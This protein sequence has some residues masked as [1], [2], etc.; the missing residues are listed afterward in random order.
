[1]VNMNL[2]LGIENRCQ[3]SNFVLKK[4]AIVRAHEYVRT[5]KSVFV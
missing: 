4:E 3:K 5:C 1:M 2:I